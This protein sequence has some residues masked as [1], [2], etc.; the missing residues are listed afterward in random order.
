MTLPNDDK[1]HDSEVRMR[2][3]LDETATS[4]TPMSGTPQTPAV[5]PRCRKVLIVDDNADAALLLGE[6]LTMMGHDVRLAHDGPQALELLQSFT[7]DLAVLDL[8]LPVMDGY[9]LAR[10]VRERLGDQVHLVAL[11]GYGQDRDRE[12]TRAAGFAEHVVKPIDLAQV[13]RIVEA[14]TDA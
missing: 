13:R 6:A 5:A 11:T 8:G 1:L 7:P 4:A 10:R 3:L 12:A 2:L 9:E 14:S